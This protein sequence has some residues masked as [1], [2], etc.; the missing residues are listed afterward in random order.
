[1]CG[2]SAVGADQFR[3]FRLPREARSP[4]LARALRFPALPGLCRPV[5][6]HHVARGATKMPKRTPRRSVSNYDE[7]TVHL[8]TAFF[9]LTGQTEEDQNIRK[10]IEAL[11]GDVARAEIAAGPSSIFGFCRN[12]MRRDH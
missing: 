2:G 12:E 9:C 11:L 5:L 6:K 7:A 10:A 1:M 4:S 8:L 3:R